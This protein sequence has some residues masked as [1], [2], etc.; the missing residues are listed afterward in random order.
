MNNSGQLV[1][2]QQR[3]SQIGCAIAPVDCNLSRKWTHGQTLLPW[4]NRFFIFAALL[5][6][7]KNT[8]ACAN[9]VFFYLKKS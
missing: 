6:R 5:N 2:E 4:C 8:K 3:K 9:V 7:K 1:T